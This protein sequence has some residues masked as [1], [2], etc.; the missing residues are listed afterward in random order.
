[1]EN[2]LQPTLEN[3]EV[4]LLSLQE[5]DFKRLYEVASDPEIWTQHPNKNRCERELFFNFFEGTMMSVGAFLILDKASGEVAGSTRFIFIMKASIRFLSAIPFMELNFEAP[6]S[7]L[8][9][10]N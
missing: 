2:F 4:K 5:S 9:L 6:N 7:I 1:M 3:D 8:R 10:R